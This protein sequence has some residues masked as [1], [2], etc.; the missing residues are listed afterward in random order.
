MQQAIQQH[1]AMAVGQHKPV[2]VGPLWVAW[3]VFEVIFPQGNGNI[4]HPH[5]HSRVARVGLLYGIHAKNTDGI[6]ELFTHEHFQEKTLL[7][8]REREERKKASK[9]IM[10][11]SPIAAIGGNQRKDLSLIK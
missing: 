1:G 10:Q 5:W 2:T 8:G 11:L 3:V 7:V 6:G 4:C 9:K